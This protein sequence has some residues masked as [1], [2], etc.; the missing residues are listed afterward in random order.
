MAPRL[1]AG[2]VKKD[3]QLSFKKEFSFLSSTK[4]SSELFQLDV[5]SVKLFGTSV[6]E[7]LYFPSS[8]HPDQSTRNPYHSHP[9]MDF[10]GSGTV[11]GRN[12]KQPPEMYK[13]L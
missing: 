6:G 3:K 1:G 9:S 7:V 8:R 11:D 2:A 5:P 4:S 13:T 10:F 12:P